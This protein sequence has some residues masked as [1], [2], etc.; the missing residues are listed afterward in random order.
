MS[1]AP[2]PADRWPDVTLPVLV[3]DGGASET[4]MHTGANALAALLP[5]ACRETLEG[6]THQVEPEA[7]GPLLAAFFAR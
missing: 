3:M 4:F 7:I 1:G 6:Q 5:D 2:L